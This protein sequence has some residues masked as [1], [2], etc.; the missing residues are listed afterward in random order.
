LGTNFLNPN[1]WVL[2]A[3]NK[4]HFFSINIVFNSSNSGVITSSKATLYRNVVTD[5]WSATSH[6]QG[7]YAA[8]LSSLVVEQNVF[9]HNGWNAS[10]P[11]A[12][13]TIYNRN[14]YIQFNND[15]VTFTGNISANSSSE[16]AQFRSGGTIS[17]NLFV[18]DSDGFDLGHLEGEPTIISAVA[19]G[20]VILNSTDIHASSG[21]LPRNQGINVFNASG[22]GVQITHNIIA[23]AAGSWVNEGGIILDATTMNVSAT[24]NIIYDV[25]NPILNSGKD[26]ITS[27]NSINLFDYQDPTRSV[28]TY[29]ASIGGSPNL[30][31]FLIEARKQSKATWRTRYTATAVNNYIRPGFGVNLGPTLMHPD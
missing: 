12:E 4:F 23:H 10:I 17:D 31:A 18:A 6:S 13:A 25:A 22:S 11:G 16:G 19:T 8:G 15:A 5:A 14:V 1:T 9:D 27:P 20:N 26:N 28:E 7:L 29:N 2:L 24:H 30:S 3:A 21:L